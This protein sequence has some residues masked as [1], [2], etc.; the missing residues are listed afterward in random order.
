MLN[1]AL[2]GNV[3]SGK[4]AVMDWFSKWGATVIDADALVREAQQP[5]TATFAAIVRR[6]G[7]DVLRSDG[8]LDRAALRS[9]VLGHDEALASL[10]AIVHPAVKRRRADLAAEALRRGDRIL[11]NDIPLLFE[12][13][14]PD[15]FDLVILVDAPVEVR[16]ERLLR[17]RGLSE[18]DADRFIAAQIPSEHKR[19][20]S[21]IVIENNGSLDDLETKA[22]DAWR[23]I[24]E[25]ATT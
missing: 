22:R 5:G 19:A 14:D 21:D 4:S 9:K 17:K 3:A 6:F 20:R 1:V 16:R 11:V 18:E 12:V 2:T 8:S 13:L 25:R 24:G 15:E 23:A 7:S 10:N